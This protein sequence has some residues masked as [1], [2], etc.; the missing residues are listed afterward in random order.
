METIEMI[1]CHLADNPDDPGSV[2]YIPLEIYAMWRFL[3]QR[4]HN[5]VVNNP[6]VSVWIPADSF[7]KQGQSEPPEQT[8]IVIEI[9]FRYMESEN[10][11]R[12]VIRYFPEENFDH[13]FGF[14]RKHFPNETKMEGVQRRR[15]YYLSAS[16]V[17]YEMGDL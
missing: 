8:D 15:G 17:P 11:G 3:M 1:K 10:I 9:K 5:L 2:R 14:F 4:V 13:I 7:E 12:P 6:T 16:A